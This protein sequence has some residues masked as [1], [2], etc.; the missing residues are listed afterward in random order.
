MT[1]GIA[2]S[3]DAMIY[4]VLSDLHIGAA[5]LAIIAGT[6]VVM[7]RKGTWTHRMVGYVYVAAMLALNISALA[8][9]RRTG[10]FGPFHY[11]AVFSLV[12]VLAGFGAVWMH[13]PA[14]RW[15]ELHL[16]LMA[17][18]YIGL[19]AAAAS[20]AAVRIP[21]APFWPAVVLSSLAILV[22]GG[23]VLNRRHDALVERH[24]S[25]R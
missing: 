14:A 11:A 5:V 24:G 9:F 7:R 19:L 17:W 1:P 18:S 12:T 2:P 16:E 4:S 21:A 6:A 15:V 22:A 3:D 10:S 13:R 23:V 25:V 20:E 8:I